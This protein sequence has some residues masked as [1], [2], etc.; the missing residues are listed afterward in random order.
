[1]AAAQALPSSKQQCKYCGL[2][3][4]SRNKLFAHLDTVHP[5]TTSS[6]A[7]PKNKVALLLSIISRGSRGENITSHGVGGSNIGGRALSWLPVALGSHQS[8]EERLWIALA[9]LEICAEG[10]MNS[11]NRPPG[12]S[13]AT[14]T[15]ARG[16]PFFSQP[17]HIPSVSEL[18]CFNAPP[19]I[20][21]AH[22]SQKNT[23]TE[24]RSVAEIWVERLNAELR[25]QNGNEA[26]TKNQF[27]QIRVL[28][29]CDLDKGAQCVH[30]ENS[31]EV[32]CYEVLV[33]LSVL[34]PDLIPFDSHRTGDGTDHGKANTEDWIALFRRLKGIMQRFQGRHNWHNYCRG[35]LPHDAVARTPKLIRFRHTVGDIRQNGNG[36]RGNETVGKKEIG[37]NGSA[38]DTA[39]SDEGFVSLCL[40]GTCFLRG[41]PQAL[42]TMAIMVLRGYLPDAAIEQSLRPDVIL[43]S[44]STVPASSL[45]LS[46]S[47]DKGISFPDLLIPDS[48]T[49]YVEG[50]YDNYENKYRLYLRPPLQPA[51]VPGANEIPSQL[52]TK[53]EH[54]GWQKGFFRPAFRDSVEDARARVVRFLVEEERHML[55]FSKW[56]VMVEASSTALR[57]SFESDCALADFAMSFDASESSTTNRPTVDILPPEELSAVLLSSEAPKQVKLPNLLP[58]SVLNTRDT[59]PRRINSSIAT[60]Y[61]RTL[62]L[63]RAADSSGMWPAS[64]ATR[65]RIIFN[66]KCKITKEPQ[67]LNQQKKANDKADQSCKKKKLQK[68]SCASPTSTDDRTGGGSFALGTMPPPLEY[69]N[70]NKLFFD[71]MCTAFELEDAILDEESGIK[72]DEN[73]ERP[74]PAHLQRRRRQSSSTIAVN[75]N[76]QFSPHTDSGSGAGQQS[77]SLIVG[78]G[79]Y[80]G[81]E[82]VVE[83]AV[84]NIRYRPLAFDGWT[85][86]HWTLPFRGERFSLVWF[87]PFGCEGKSGLELCESMKLSKQMDI[88]QRN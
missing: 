65:A 58:A 4:E 61:N 57:Q 12:W 16:S 25:L 75:R 28:A 35:V 86:R 5:G 44:V 77:V 70:A 22:E 48:T 13:R 64:S 7:A 63:L 11:V 37:G 85:Q 53:V 76:A 18:V 23:S 30:A 36:A 74:H 8:L 69:P 83:G 3:F 68:S 9:K 71:L 21:K 43:R 33:P 15:E 88:Q 79:D 59:I 81:G 20:A 82:L 80:S 67:K 17:H 24:E 72:D 29:R 50:K 62:E 14:A 55:R 26:K 47:Q 54:Q 38:R 6:S 39:F 49:F 10:D 66:D 34:A 42:V 51:C 52:D 1:M 84:H 56:M 87:T 78:L 46:S 60:L 40:H 27:S 2:T 19:L 45:L 32:R 41:M 31:C 73:D